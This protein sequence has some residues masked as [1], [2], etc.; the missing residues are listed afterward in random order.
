MKKAAKKGMQPRV[1][2][3]P[4]TKEKFAPA[5]ILGILL[6]TTLVF[7]GTLGLGWTNWDDDVYIFEN[8]LVKNPD[9]YR[10]FTEPS[11]STYNPMVILSWAMEWKQAGMEPFLYHLDNL[12]LHLAC[13]LFVFLILRQLGLRLL[14]AALGTLV[15]SI[16]PLKVESVA[17]A[18]ERKDLLYAFFYLAAIWQYLFYLKNKKTLHLAFT[19][20]L[21]ILSLFSKIQAVTLAPVLVLLDWYK[22]RKMDARVIGEK[23]PFFIGALLIGWMGV[24]FLKQGNVISIEGPDH[25]LTERAVF[26]MY[27]YAQ[28]LIKFLIPYVTCTYYPKTQDLKL[29][30]YLFGAASVVFILI[31]AL[32]YRKTGLFSFS[33]AFFTANV[34]LL[35]QIVEAGSAFMADRFTYVAYAGLVL[36]LCLTLQRLSDKKPAWKIPFLAALSILL[37][38][39]GGLTYNYVK[40]WENSDTLWTDVIDKYPRK[41]VIA[42]VNRG[43]Y[44]RRNGERERAF[45]DFNTAISLKPEYHLSYLNRGNIYFDRNEAENAEKDYLH[46]IDLKKKN[47]DKAAME[48]D[49]ELGDVYG[50]LGAIYAKTGRYDSA[51]MYLNM[52]VR[53]NPGNM[54]HLMNRGQTFFELNRYPESTADFEASLALKPD[55]P[56]M[57]NSIGVNYLREGKPDKAKNYFD[58]AIALNPG[59]GLFFMNRALA[60]IQLKDRIRAGSDLEAARKLGIPANPQMLQLLENIK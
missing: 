7:S 29:I 37:V 35:L 40:A 11:A 5:Y 48:N 50:N 57:L 46:F 3:A 59:Q 53:I 2:P 22:G 24:Q 45:E 16:H 32:R 44:L 26:G 28:Y 30:H 6:I 10:I 8:P 51:L 1:A 54:N 58:K 18:T 43:H 56:V 23:I 41:V 12:L 21:F 47:L 60:F 9:L 14:W 31:T 42:Y 33:I 25:T 38:V 19:F 34:I 4:A 36:L 27:A 52:A 20:L 49:P 39:F 13:T 55:N 15:F 17:W